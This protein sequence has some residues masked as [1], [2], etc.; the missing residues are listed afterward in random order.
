[1]D[2]APTAELAHGVTTRIALEANEPYLDLEVT[3][4]DKPAD[5]WPEAGWIC[6]PLKV[7]SPQFRLGRLGSIVDPTRDVVP[8]AN[9]HVFAINTGVA[10]FDAQ[11]R[12]AGVCAM[13][14]PW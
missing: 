12:G 9:R 1:M 2:S 11:G 4:H 14:S 7:D 5:P 6:L 3:V 10:V 8:G 13:D